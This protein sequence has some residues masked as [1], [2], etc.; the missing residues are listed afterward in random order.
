MAANNAAAAPPT[1]DVKDAMIK[2]GISNTNNYAG[3]SP[4]ERIATQIFDDDFQSCM[5]LQM[6]ELN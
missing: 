1:Y 6:D 4:A 2:C 5:D 3:T